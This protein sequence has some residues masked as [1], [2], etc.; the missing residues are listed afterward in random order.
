M[1]GEGEGRSVIAVVH[2]TLGNII[3]ADTRFFVYLAAFQNHFV[4]NEAGSAPVNDAIRILEASSQIIGAQYRYLGG[5]C[6]SFRSHHADV[7]VSDGQDACTAER[8]ACNLVG[9]IAEDTVS[10]QER[11][12]MFC[13][14]DRSYARSAAAVRR[15]KRLVQVQMANVGADKARVRQSYLCIHIGA[16]HIYLCTASVDNAADFHNL[17]FKDAVRRGIGNHQRSKVV[18]ILFC[19]GAKV[20]HIHIALFVAGASHG[21]ETRLNGGCRIG[22]MRRCRNQHLVAMSLP[23]AFQVSAD[24]TEPCI[25]A[26]RTG[27]GLQADAGKAGDY[28]Q[29]FAEVVY[30]FA[31]TLCLVFGHQRM[32]IHKF[33]PAEGQHLCRSIQLHG[34]RTEGNHGVCQGDV[35]A[36]EALDV[37]HHLRLRVIFVE[38]LVRQVGALAFQ[39]LTDGIAYR[40]VVH[41]RAVLSGGNGKDR[42]QYVDGSYVR[43]FVNAHAHVAVLEVTQVHFLAQCDGAYLLCRDGIGQC[44]AERVEILCIDLLVSQFVD[45]FLQIYGNAVDAFGNGAYAFRP[46]IYG[47]EACHGGK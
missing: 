20:S 3:F 4:A 5:T 26:C 6:Q 10:R 47:V 30:Q 39:F 9:S 32:Y 36:V 13:H 35:L 33:R 8:S 7:S 16:V 22:T 44:E 21:S 15:S 12:Q 14:A 45:G 37:A 40:H 27:V 31:I 46:V 28:L 11:N 29:F 43:A 38:Y 1:Y 41:L 24:N 2:Q 17:R 18:L 25:F 42:Y 23:D 19:F 34:A